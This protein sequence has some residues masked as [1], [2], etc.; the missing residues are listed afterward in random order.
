MKLRKGMRVRI[1]N[2]LEKSFRIHGDA[3]DM[4]QMKNKEYRIDD[5]R[6]GQTVHIRMGAFKRFMF[7]PDDLIL[8][9][10]KLSPNLHMKSKESILFN[11]KNLCT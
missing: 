10:E 7:H 6:D 9:N 2:N 4:H 8:I 1:S 5:I 3:F 11:P